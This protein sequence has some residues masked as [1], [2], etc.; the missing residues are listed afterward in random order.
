M[1]AT[2]QGSFF[3]GRSV[4]KEKLPGE[5]KAEQGEGGGGRRRRWRRGKSLGKEKEEEKRRY[6]MSI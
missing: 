5:E 1:H 4:F 3:Y 6:R 2:V